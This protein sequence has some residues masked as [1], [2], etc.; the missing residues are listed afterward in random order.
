MKKIA[1]IRRGF[2]VR[3]FKVIRL[4]DMVMINFFGIGIMIYD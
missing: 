1:I 4:S 2:K 3:R